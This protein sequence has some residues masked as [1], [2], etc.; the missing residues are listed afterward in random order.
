MRNSESECCTLRHF[1][2]NSITDRVNW[3]YSYRFPSFFCV[4][5]RG[6]ISFSAAQMNKLCTGEARFNCNKALIIKVD[7]CLG[8]NKTAATQTDAAVLVFYSSRCTRGKTHG[9]AL[10]A[11]TPGCAWMQ[12]SEEQHTH[13]HKPCNKT[14]SDTSRLKKKSPAPEPSTGIDLKSKTFIPD[15]RQ[16]SETNTVM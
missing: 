11:K 3:G 4:C 12:V 1:R 9:R 13:C 10:N 15:S 7:T 5:L 14:K 6:D 16:W 2:V 8:G